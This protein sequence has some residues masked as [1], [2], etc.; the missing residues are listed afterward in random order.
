MVQKE[1]QFLERVVSW[2]SGGVYRRIREAPC[3]RSWPAAPRRRSPP[4]SSLMASG[5]KG[6]AAGWGR[7][8]R[9]DKGRGYRAGAGGCSGEL[10]RRCRDS[11]WALAAARPR[12]EGPAQQWSARGR[13]S[14][15]R[16]P[17]PPARRPHRPLPRLR[18][19]PPSPRRPRLLSARRTW[20]R[21][22]GGTLYLS[23]GPT[24]CAGTAASSSSSAARESGDAGWGAGRAGVRGRASAPRAAAALTGA[25][26]SP[27]RPPPLH[28]LATPA[29]RGTSQ[30]WPHDPL[31]WAPGRWGG[32]LGGGGRAP[33]WPKSD[34]TFLAFPQTC[35]AAGRR[36][37]RRRAP[38][39]SSSE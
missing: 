15:P 19:L 4:C 7:G 38:V 16:G 12:P 6:R 32:A 27:Q 5:A 31:R 2:V 25:S 21:R 22:S 1:V 23:T 33:G 17:S 9:G 37:S 28:N 11:T 20:R 29:H 34:R 36:A 13:S 35:P 10:P 30:L 24:A 26:L 18:P 14:G 3:L 8:R 39:T